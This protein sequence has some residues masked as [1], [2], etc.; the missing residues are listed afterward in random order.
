MSDA[1]CSVQTQATAE[2]LLHRVHQL[3]SVADRLLLLARADAGRLELQTDEFD[4]REL[5]DGVLNDA[6]VLAEPLGL[7]VEAEVPE[8]LSLKADRAFVGM[9]TQNLI[10]NA[11]K[12]N[13]PGGPGAGCGAEGKRFDRTYDRQHRRRYSSRARASFV[14][15][16]S[17]RAR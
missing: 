5:L 2:G 13:S 6:R 16:F 14:R 12:Y 4:L 3:N 8:R 7:T 15:A 11:I 10:E 1:E 17:P 9:I